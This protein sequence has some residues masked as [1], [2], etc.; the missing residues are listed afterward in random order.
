MFM[1]LI[2]EYIYIYFW[3]ICCL[4]IASPLC[5]LDYL[6]SLFHQIILLAKVILK[7]I[8]MMQDVCVVYAFSA[9]CKMSSCSGCRVQQP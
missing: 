9:R 4:L 6:M 8:Q 5:V 7:E 3:N 1:I 2:Y